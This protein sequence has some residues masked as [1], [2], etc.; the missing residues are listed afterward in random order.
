VDFLETY[1]QYV[2][3]VYGYFAYRLRSRADAED[4]TQLT[5]ERALA[6]WDRF[7]ENR[8]DVGVWL[9]AIA[10]NALTDF[11]RRDRSRRHISLSTGSLTDA[12]LPRTEMREPGF[13][14][15]L[16]AALGRLSR[17]E[18]GLIALRF[19]ADLSGPQIAELLDM[20]LSNVHQILSRALRKLRVML[21]PRRPKPRSRTSS[22]AR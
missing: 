17:R 8:A 9:L 2:W 5:F 6:A 20:S 4:L 7:D 21:E 18:R 13:D 14:P 1:E 12:D 22:G 16:A 3:K 10:R 19:G 11:Y 15:E